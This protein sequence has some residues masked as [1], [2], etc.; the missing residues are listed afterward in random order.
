[1]VLVFVRFVT[2]SKKCT[3]DSIGV[4]RGR[5][6]INTDVEYYFFLL[7]AS[8]SSL[9]PLYSYISLIPTPSSLKYLLK[10]KGLCAGLSDIFLLSSSSPSS[11]LP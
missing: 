4:L 8:N 1:M 2:C 6:S 5:T 3:V 7:S 10:P 9:Y 11:Y